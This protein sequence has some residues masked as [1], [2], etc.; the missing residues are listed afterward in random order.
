MM[1]HHGVLPQPG[2]RNA[3]TRSNVTTPMEE[4]YEQLL[5]KTFLTIRKAFVLSENKRS[6]D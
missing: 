4:N 2:L 1:I 5:K 6:C 3:V